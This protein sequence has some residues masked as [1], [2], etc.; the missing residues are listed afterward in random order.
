MR[1]YFNILFIQRSRDRKPRKNKKNIEIVTF[2]TLPVIPKIVSKF[3]TLKTDHLLK[4]VL[5]S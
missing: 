1:N 4:L 3:I 2:C 5:A